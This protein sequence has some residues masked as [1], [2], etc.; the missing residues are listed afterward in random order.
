MDIVHRLV[1]AGLSVGL[2]PI[3]FGGLAVELYDFF[4]KPP[5]AKRQEEYMHRLAT[6]LERL[7][8]RSVDVESLP[9]NQKFITIVTQAMVI[10]LRNHQ[11]EKLDALQNVILNAAIS[12]DSDE[13]LELMFLNYIDIFTPSHL[14]VLD[15]LDKNE[16]DIKGGA[17]AKYVTPAVYEALKS[18]KPK[19]ADVPFF[20]I[21]IRDLQDRELINPMTK[22]VSD[23][24]YYATITT[25]M[26]KSFLAYI[27]F[28]D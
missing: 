13:D 22:N 6:G 10:S 4:I 15:Y 23:E 9:N 7:E 28:S 20:N 14:E 2:S 24:T 11:K 21:I 27:T 3:P 12:Y 18:V 5:L 8:K 16:F 26:G 1:K 19:Y 25:K 17:H